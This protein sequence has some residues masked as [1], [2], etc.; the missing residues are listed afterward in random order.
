MKRFQF[1]FAIFTIVFALT[2]VE[3]SAATFTVTNANDSG[4]GSFRQALLDANVNNEDDTINFDS[5]VF[6]TPQ[7]IVLTSGQLV[8]EADR[9]SGTTKT[10]TING[11]GANLLTL[12]GNNQSR[13]L[14]LDFWARGIISGIKI[15]RGNGT[16]GAAG[17]EFNN[18][19]G[20]LLVKGGYNGDGLRNL[21]LRDSIITGNKVSAPG[22]GGG[23]FLGWYA[24]VINTTISNNEALTGA[25]GGVQAGSSSHVWFVNSTVSGNRSNRG[26][27][28]NNNG[29]TIYLTNSTVAF[30]WAEGGGGGVLLDYPGQYGISVGYMRNTIVANNTTNSVSG[31][32]ADASGAFHSLGYN[33][34][35]DSRGMQFHTSTNLTGNQMDVDAGLDYQLRNNGG[36]MP[37]HALRAN[38]PAIDAGDNCVLSGSCA[39]QNIANITSD[40][41]G[42]TRPQDGNGDGTMKVDI[43]AFEATRAEIVS[44]P[45]GAPDLHAAN[46]TGA[47]STDN[48]TSSSTLTFDVSGLTMGATIELL[49]DGAVVATTTAS[50]NSA[51]LNDT[52][53]TANGVHVYS[54]RQIIDN[55]TSL[56][57]PALSVTIDNAA[58][59]VTLTQ[60]SWQADPTNAQ[61]INYSVTFSEAV[62][63][64]EPADVSLAGSTA[65]VSSATVAVSGSGT[66]Y[67][68]GV[69]NISGDGTIVASIPQGAV[70]DVAGNL[71]QASTST[72]NTVTYDATRPTATINRQ[73]R[74]RNRPEIFRLTSPSFSANPLPDLPAPTFRLPVQRRLSV[75]PRLRLREAA[76]L[77]TSPSAISVPTAVLFARLF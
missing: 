5:A 34:I 61:P 62:S 59:T 32:Y 17:T 69:I 20:G 73:P 46:D 37:T 50:G 68:I 22:I 31:W 26:G 13:V 21:I 53:V 9:S 25:G 55:S 23:A 33:I 72:D 63:V 60:A 70:Q 11:P 57:G 52:G 2:A 15:T 30:N 42:V 67:T 77:I 43:G 27:G 44:A 58:P 28:I 45:T 65:G 10:L 6:S 3:T 66:A 18:W 7:T 64:F 38:S 12:D 56:Q 4:A 74:R 49:R 47:S 24:E 75:P 35:G 19:G 76:R 39:E 14:M 16:G 48:I 41:R 8:I 71:S 1:I 51:I 36:V 40:L 54:T 29:G